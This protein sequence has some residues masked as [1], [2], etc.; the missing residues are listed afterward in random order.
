M[1][2]KVIIV[3]GPSGSGKS[4]IEKLLSEKFPNEFHKLQQVSTRPMREGEKQGDPY[5]FVTQDEYD[6]IKDNLIGRTNINGERYGTIFDLVDGKYN[7]II[8]N[9]MGIDDFINQFP[10]DKCGIDY[11][12]VMIDSRQLVERQNRDISYIMNERW[13]IME[14]MNLCFVHNPPE[15]KTVEEVR[16]KIITFFNRYFKSIN[17]N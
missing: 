2:K 9:K 4:M 16:D 7:T 5:K 14:V 11:I 1:N 8:L 10:L 13:N 15:Y 12:I 6:E 17:K 3:A